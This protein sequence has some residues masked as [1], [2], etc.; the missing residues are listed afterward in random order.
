MYQIEKTAQVFAE[1]TKY[2]LPLL[3][4]S[5]TR[6]TQTEQRRTP[7]GELLLFAEHDNN[8]N[9]YLIKRPY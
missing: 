5:E 1:M 2:K 4:I 7:T 6:W 9:V 3:G 8:N